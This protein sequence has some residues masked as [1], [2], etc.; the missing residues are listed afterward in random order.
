MKYIPFT[1]TKLY[2]PPGI[3]ARATGAWR[4]SWHD[5]NKQVQGA[6]SFI[7]G[8]PCWRM[9]REVIIDLPVRLAEV[10]R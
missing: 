1:D 5:A 8:W 9:W 10:R 2:G 3:P 4:E 6:L 7:L